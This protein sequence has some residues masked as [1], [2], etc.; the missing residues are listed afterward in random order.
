MKTFLQIDSVKTVLAEE[1][2]NCQHEGMSEEDIE[3]FAHGF[4][5]AVQRLELLNRDDSGELN[6]YAEEIAQYVYGPDLVSTSQEF[7]QLR[8]GDD[9]W[10]R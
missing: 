2:G 7:K 3:V 9:S 8:V 6:R 1:V 5:R 4:C 10:L